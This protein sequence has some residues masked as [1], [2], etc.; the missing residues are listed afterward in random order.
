MNLKKIK[1]IVNAGYSDEVARHLL[2]KTLAEDETLIPTLLEI[3]GS[4]RKRNGK[5]LDDFNLQLSRAHIALE[6]ATYKKGALN[7][8]HFV[9]KEI[10][11]FFHRHKDNK[12][13]GHLF[14]K[15]S[16]MP[17][18]EKEEKGFYED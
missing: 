7:H 18:P 16:E 9:E 12:R 15:L 14:K 17:E 4:E 11:A 8:D 5:A 2:I 3:L 1:E 13:I 10:I 6:T